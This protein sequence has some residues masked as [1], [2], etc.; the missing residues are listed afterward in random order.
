MAVP[1]LDRSR[2]LAFLLIDQETRALLTSF[3]RFLEP[4]IDGMLDTFYA[5]LGATPEVAAKFGGPDRI[6]HAR[7]MQREHWLRRVFSGH[8]DEQYF[9]QA[10]QIGRVHQRIGLEPRWYTAGYCL[11][12][13]RIAAL[14]LEAYPDPA[15]AGPVLAAVNKAAFLDMDLAT[16][17]YIE[18]NTAALISRELGSKAA[19]FEK[20]VAN[21]STA[22][23]G[24]EASAK[25]LSRNAEE[26][27]QQADEVS[28]SAQA[29]SANIQTVAAAAEELSVSIRQIARQVG[30]RR[31]TAPAPS[32]MASPRP[33]AR[34][35]G[36]WP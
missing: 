25:V 4:R 26:A 27:K 12:L 20:V 32:S 11:L 1:D 29:V 14:V 17:V 34:S 8:F 33:W 18:A 2:R 21:V 23:G 5:H 31:P 6:A 22:A 3:V 36:S 16:S 24:M 28:A 10:C 19:L 13:N 30:G 7:R 9:A 35:T 15:Q